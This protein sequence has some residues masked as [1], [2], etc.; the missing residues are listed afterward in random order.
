MWRQTNVQKWIS[1]GKYSAYLS[2]SGKNG[3][4]NNPCRHGRPQTFFQGR[5][6]IFQGGAKT[7]FLPIKQQ[8]RYYFSQKSLKKCYFRPA[9]AGQ[10][11]G[12][13]HPLA[14][15]LRTPMLV[16]TIVANV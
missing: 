13:E 7:Y 10:G 11:G 14:P 6:K 3:N 5:A 9:L 12:Q 4:S 2:N 16:A 15:P 8:K 1:N